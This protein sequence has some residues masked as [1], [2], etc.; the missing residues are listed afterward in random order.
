MGL[1]VA[2]RYA[3]ALLELGIDQGKI[4]A[5]QTQLSQFAQLVD[6]S[7][8]LRNVIINPSVR[9]SERK[10]IIDAIAVKLRYDPMVKNFI[11]LLLD[12]GRLALIR[13]IALAFEEEVDLHLGNLRAT[14]VSAEALADAEVDAVRRAIV[15]MTGKTVLL[16]T[17][18]DPS[19]I[20]GVV[21]KIGS[22][23][24][25]GSIRT[26]LESLRDQVL[27]EV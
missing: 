5:Y 10:A 19:L 2:T 20:G 14:V 26:Q 22:V 8:D 25:D 11:S 23:V 1:I 4:E 13:E 12:K 6:E 27:A 15:R 7:A 24:Y 17:E 9:L 21:T 16:D 18:V 3:K